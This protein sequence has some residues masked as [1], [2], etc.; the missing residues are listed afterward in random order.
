V[1]TEHFDQEHE[2][3]FTFKLGDGHEILMIRAVV[4]AI[5]G[6][7]AERLQGEETFTLADC[8]IQDTRFFYDGQ[9]HD[10]ALY[11]RN[12]L[13]QKLVVAGPAIIT[14]MDSTTLVLPGY[15]ATID[16]VGNLLIY[17]VK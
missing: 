2:K 13:H 7:I 5:S 9:W 12:K 1:L 15:V 10:G 4:K 8:K 16:A 6:D 11:D 3:L 14:E 17:P